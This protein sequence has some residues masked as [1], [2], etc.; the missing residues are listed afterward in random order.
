MS[1]VNLDQLSKILAV[2]MTARTGD[3][4]RAIIDPE[5]DPQIESSTA[6]LSLS[7]TWDTHRLRITPS[8]PHGTREC[9]VNDSITCDPKRA[10]EAIA[11]DICAR[12]LPQA[13]KHLAE[14]IEYD[15]AQ[16]QKDAAEKLR[17]N[18]LKRFTPKEYH[19][20]R[21]TDGKGLWT[22]MTY[23]NKVQIE[24][25]VSLPEAMQILKFLK[26]RNPHK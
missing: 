2:E 18:L 19:E 7:E 20:G 24:I 23:E 1:N 6:C 21:L 3:L 15:R 4:W 16:K 26:E 22:R 17:K 14:S 25:T 11:R 9:R 5:R 13:I 8:A 10:A 12:I